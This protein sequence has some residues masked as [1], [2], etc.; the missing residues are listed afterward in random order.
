MAIK[1]SNI[2]FGNSTAN[3]LKSLDEG[4]FLSVFEGVPQ[5][6]ITK[7]CLNSEILDLFTKKTNIFNS[8][9]EAKRMI[10]SNAVS[11]NKEKITENFQI[12]EK[13]LLNKK[14]ILA[15]KG[16]KNYFLIIVTQKYKKTQKILAKD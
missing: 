5:F 9:G 14:Y 3:D 12:T 6:K 8:K 11:I 7:K 10:N 1:A 15:Q 16:K 13:H 4:T 2:L